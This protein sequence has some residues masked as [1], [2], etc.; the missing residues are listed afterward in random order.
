VVIEFIG[1]PGDGPPLDRVPGVLG[2]AQSADPRPGAAAV[3]ADARSSDAVLR[4]LLAAGDA[5]HIL[6]LRQAPD[7][8]GRPGPEDLR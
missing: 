1:Y 3:R 2:L 5:V 7:C 6:G 4:H 8:G